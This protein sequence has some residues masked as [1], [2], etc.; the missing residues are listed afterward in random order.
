M[1]NVILSREYST[2]FAIIIRFLCEYVNYPPPRLCIESVGVEDCSILK[3]YLYI[4][5]YQIPA[6]F[7]LHHYI[8][9]G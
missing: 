3:R 6:L 5:R 8:C 2:L 4:Y 9:V 1:N 7:L